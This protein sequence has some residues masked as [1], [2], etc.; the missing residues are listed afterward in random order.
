MR[1]AIGDHVGGRKMKDDDWAGVHP[2]TR[3]ERRPLP[4]YLMFGRVGV[5]AH[6][7]STLFYAVRKAQRWP[8][9]GVHLG[10]PRVNR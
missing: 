7:N 2:L 6:L 3:Y 4:G 1:G 5:P 10:V 9:V 8:Y